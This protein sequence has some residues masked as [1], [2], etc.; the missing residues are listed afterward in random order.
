MRY[1]DFVYSKL[2][3]MPSVTW[4]DLKYSRILTVTGD[5]DGEKISGNEGNNS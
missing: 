5:A 3:E 4:E 1:G 2:S